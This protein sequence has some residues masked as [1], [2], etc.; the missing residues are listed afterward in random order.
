MTVDNPCERPD[1]PRQ[2][3]AVAH[4]LD[5]YADRG[6]GRWTSARVCDYHARP[7]AIPAPDR[8]SALPEDE[9]AF[10]RAALKRNRDV[11]KALADAVLPGTEDWG[12]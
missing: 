10:R 7:E 11:K 6:R 8:I 12:R 5:G 2:A 1:C 9:T 3:Q 4:Y